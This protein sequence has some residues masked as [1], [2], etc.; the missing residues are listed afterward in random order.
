MDKRISRLDKA[1]KSIADVLEKNKLLFPYKMYQIKINWKY[2]MGPQMA[3]YSYIREFKKDIVV[4]GVLN[5]VWMNHLFL[6]K[7]ILPHP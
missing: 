3:K 1:G 7:K 6:Y 4:I 2:I 5:S